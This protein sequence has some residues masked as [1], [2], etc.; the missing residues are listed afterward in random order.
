MKSLYESILDND[1]QNKVQ[2]QA[3]HLGM[4]KMKDVIQGEP[5]V[6]INC[7]S[8]DPA[9]LSDYLNKKEIAKDTT[10]L[11]PT[12]IKWK[13]I[14]NKDNLE[15]LENLIRALYDQPYLNW[16]QNFETYLRNHVKKTFEAFCEEDWTNTRSNYNIKH[17]IYIIR[18]NS[19]SKSLCVPLEL[20]MTIKINHIKHS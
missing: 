1:Y 2:S 6:H 16:E 14:E 15:I 5:I 4:L 7:D 17:I 12:G 13:D 8:F 3:T 19:N 11:N 10:K 20:S 9:V 18:P